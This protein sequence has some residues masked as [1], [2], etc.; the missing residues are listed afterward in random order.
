MFKH[1]TAVRCKAHM[2]LI[3]TTAI[4]SAQMRMMVISLACVVV[5][6]EGYVS[7]FRLKSLGYD[8]HNYRFFGCNQFQIR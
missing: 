5:L 7:T 8:D 3:P 6:V 2:H 1:G 4:H